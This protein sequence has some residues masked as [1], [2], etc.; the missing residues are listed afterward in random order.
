VSDAGGDMNGNS[1]YV[2][3]QNFNLASMQS[4][5]NLETKVAHIVADSFRTTHGTG[6]AVKRGQKSVSE[7]FNLLATKPGEFTTHAAVVHLQKTSPFT[8]AKRNRALRR[9]NYICEQHC[10]KRTVRFGM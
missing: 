10:R 7:R 8:I 3:R 5:P 2:I 6:G 1:A 9:A 4:G